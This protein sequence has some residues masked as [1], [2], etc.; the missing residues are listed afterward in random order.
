MIS[1]IIVAGGK[2]ERFGSDKKYIMFNGKTFLENVVEKASAFSDEIIVSL[3]KDDEI[4]GII[5]K[6]G[7]K[8]AFDA[9]NWKSPLA[10]ICSSIDHCRGEYVV[11]L[12]VDS[13]SIK[14]EIFKDMVQEC[15]LFDAVIPARKEG[16]LEVLHAVY[17]TSSLKAACAKTTESGDHSVKAMTEHL[18]E[19][20]VVDVE[21]FRRFDPDLL[22]FINVNSEEDLDRL[23]KIEK[24]G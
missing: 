7:L 1:C 9:V 2:S 24:E 13:P 18:G 15:R 10:G 3:G 20:N 22:T 16:R 6:D 5:E 4:K 17:K 21:R 8:I 12:S 19:V 23:I 14:P 11:V